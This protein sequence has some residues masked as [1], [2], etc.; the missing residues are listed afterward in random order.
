MLDNNNTYICDCGCN[1]E[2]NC[3]SLGIEIHFINN[4]NPINKILSV[5]KIKNASWNTY[6]DIDNFD[7]W[8][9][10]WN[11]IQSQ[12]N[13]TNAMQHLYNRYQNMVVPHNAKLSL[14]YIF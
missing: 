13:E 9:E 12:R 1:I 10:L 6:L 4:N 2:F 14:E 8:G 5:S 7:T 3:N 11:Y